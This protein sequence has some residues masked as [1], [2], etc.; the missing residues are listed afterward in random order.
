MKSFLSSAR[1][2]FERSNLLVKSLSIFLICFSFIYINASKYGLGLSAD[3]INYLSIAKN[4]STDFSFTTSVTEWNFEGTKYWNAYWPPLY[5]I[6]L[7]LP[8]IIGNKLAFILFNALLLSL[9]V[10]LSIK[11]MER[12]CSENKIRILLSVILIVFSRWVLWTF[13]FMLSETLFIPLVLAYLLLLDNLIKERNDKNYILLLVVTCML[14]LTRYIGIFFFLPIIILTTPSYF[15]FQ[16]KRIIY[17]AVSVVPFFVILFINYLE[18]G[19]L[20]GIR[21]KNSG[22]YFDLFKT[23]SEGTGKWITGTKINDGLGIVIFFVFA[24]LIVILL[25]RLFIRGKGIN[26]IIIISVLVYMLAML[27][28]ALTEKLEKFGFRFLSPV[29]IPAALM[30]LS[31]AIK[32]KKKIFYSLMIICLLISSYV[33]VRFIN[34]NRN[35]GIGVFAAKEWQSSNTINY[36]RQNWDGRNIY[37][38]YAEALQFYTGKTTKIIT[39][40]KNMIGEMIG[41]VSREHAAIVIINSNSRIQPETVELIKVVSANRPHKIFNDGVIYYY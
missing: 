40:E 8:N 24:G 5:P 18:T 28:S 10:L 4:I 14:S 1:S 12:I 38:N 31:M 34:T 11:L 37:S 6:T 33:V 19:R 2:I 39:D 25:Y 21:S 27:F 20:F 9:T 17:L 7:I 36:V 15:I 3:S 22:S 23:I 16:L 29:F 35:Y 32:L 13:S 26:K 30:I 41:K